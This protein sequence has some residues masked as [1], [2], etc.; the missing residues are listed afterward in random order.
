M[1]EFL[2]TCKIV[3]KGGAARIA[4]LVDSLTLKQRLESLERVEEKD[5]GSGGEAQ[6]KATRR[7]LGGNSTCRQSLTA[8]LATW[9]H[10]I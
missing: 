7:Q 1:Q 5:E 2:P 9:T 8:H 6:S 3:R 10:L 4:G